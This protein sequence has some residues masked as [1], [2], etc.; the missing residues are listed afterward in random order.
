MAF[1]TSPSNNQVW[2]EG[3]RAFVF[4]S[5]TS[6]WDRVREADSSDNKILSGEI[7]AGVILPAGLKTKVHV[8]PL[9]SDVNCTGSGYSTYQTVVISP[10]SGTSKLYVSHTLHV[11]QGTGGS[12]S[13]QQ[14]LAYSGSNVT[15]GSYTTSEAYQQ[16]VSAGLY[17]VRSFMYKEVKLNGTA[18]DVTFLFK[19]YHSHVNNTTYVIG[20]NEMETSVTVIEV[21]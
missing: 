16:A 18:S 5:A 19:V 7:G 14:E 13:F 11:N 3:N 15:N 9:A 4:D 12:A 17:R 2:K 20:D 21:Y 6:V 1:P 8:H 10:S